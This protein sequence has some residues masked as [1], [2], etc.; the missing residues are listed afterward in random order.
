MLDEPTA[1][2]ILVSAIHEEWSRRG[3]KIEG[4]TAWAAVNAA[5]QAAKE[6]AGRTVVAPETE[7]RGARSG[8]A[9]GSEAEELRSGIEQ[10][11]ETY[12]HCEDF[13]GMR[14]RMQRLLDRVNMR[15]SSTHEVHEERQGERDAVNIQ[16]RWYVE[17][18]ATT[19]GVHMLP[20]TTWEGL[21]ADVALATEN[22]RQVLKFSQTL[23]EIAAEVGLPS[24]TESGTHAA[25]DVVE[26]VHEAVSG[27]RREVD[28]LDRETTT[29]R[30]AAGLMAATDPSSTRVSRG[31]LRSALLVWDPPLSAPSPPTS[32]TLGISQ[33]SHDDELR[34]R[35]VD[36]LDLS[37]RAAHCLANSEIR[38]FGELER[39]TAAGILRIKGA[40]RRVVQNI[41]E[42][43][44]ALPQKAPLPHISGRCL[45]SSTG[46]RSARWR[47]GSSS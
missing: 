7:R 37:V 5:S 2:A 10:I 12:A 33:V 39:W 25:A 38:T 45:R 1:R 8:V 6:I 31:L 46:N 14:G 35:S 18:L 36:D 34:S 44:A 26:A 24:Q 15:D 11:I 27:L 47:H 21:L 42:A 17:Q 23:G 13:T 22:S 4:S 32:A 16:R 40:N 3:W 19:L 41:V 29:A 28:R 30:L 20:W 43:F 9:H